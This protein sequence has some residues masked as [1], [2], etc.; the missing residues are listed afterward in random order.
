VFCR[1]HVVLPSIIDTTY[2]ITTDSPDSTSFGI[3]S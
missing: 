2:R 1:P 3:G